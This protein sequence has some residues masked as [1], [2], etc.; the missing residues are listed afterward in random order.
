MST[1]STNEYDQWEALKFAEKTLKVRSVAVT[2][3][4]SLGSIYVQETSN[5]RCFCNSLQNGASE[6]VCLL[7]S[8]NIFGT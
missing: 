7:Y 2:G 6:N 8:T 4:A 3:Q 1:L 5:N